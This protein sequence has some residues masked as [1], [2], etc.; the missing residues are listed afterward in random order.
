MSIFAA[1]STRIE[2]PREE[3]KIDE[4]SIYYEMDSSN[5]TKKKKKKGFTFYSKKL[6]RN[7]I[8][9]IRTSP[10]LDVTV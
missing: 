1:S 7:I 8:N 10:L 4:D 6:I 5:D 2:I 9:D 3:R